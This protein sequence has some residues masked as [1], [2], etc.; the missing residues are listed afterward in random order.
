MHEL[1]IAT[2]LIG[3]VVETAEANNAE[4]VNKITAK[5]GRLA[6][7]DSNALQFAFEAIKDEYP[8]ITGAEL[9]IDYVPITGRCNACGKTHEYEEMC[10]ECA[11]CGSYD[12]VLL[13][14]E[15][16]TVSDIEVD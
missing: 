8:L 11:S 4:K 14:G 7:V 9:I 5:I 13:T 6:G 12:V 16:M 3:I 15:E 1:G 2:S 10:F